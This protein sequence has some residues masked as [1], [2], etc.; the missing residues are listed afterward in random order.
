[1]QK[2]TDAYVERFIG[3]LLQIGVILS[4][5]VVLLGGIVYLT[6]HGHA[7]PQYRVFTGEPTDLRRITGILHEALAGKGR[8]IIQLGLLLLIATPVAR[9]TFSVGA[10]ARE[11]DGLYVAITLAVL[12]ILVCSLMSGQG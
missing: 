9:V 12:A 3:S 2:W 1:M 7:A 10:F 6:R 11:R 4:S 8:G 5:L